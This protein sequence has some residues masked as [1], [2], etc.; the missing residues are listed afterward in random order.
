M[1]DEDLL[2]SNVVF[3]L[4]ADLSIVESSHFDASQFDLQN[5]GDLLGKGFVGIASKDDHILSR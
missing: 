3:N 4:N 2:G 5:L 1:N